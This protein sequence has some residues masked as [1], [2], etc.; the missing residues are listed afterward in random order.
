[1]NQP[2]YQQ[3]MQPQQQWGQPPMQQPMQPQQ[4]WGQ[5]PAQPMNPSQQPIAGA[6]ANNLFNQFLQQPVRQRADRAKPPDGT[7]VV[8]FTQGTK[9]DFSQKDGRPFL[10]LEY[11]VIEG[12]VP[13]V[14]GQTFGTPIFSANRMQL[15][16]L[17]NL[18]KMVFG[19]DLPQVAAQAQGDPSNMGRFIAQQLSR[20]YF[21]ALR[22]SR[23]PKQVAQK[24]YEE[25]FANHRW[26]GFSPQPINMAQVQAMSP[27]PQPQM[28]MPQPGMAPPPMLQPQGMPPQQQTF[29]QA[30]LPQ[31]APQQPVWQQPQQA[32]VQAQPQWQQPAPQQAPV[33]QFQQAFQLPQAPLPQGQLPQAQPP[34]SA[35]VMLPQA[36]AQ[37]LPQAP[38]MYIPGQR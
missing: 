31:A 3:P 32:P 36:G 17:A 30:P 4:Q 14:N 16:D 24:G 22:I 13:Q 9:V 5:P 28:Q 23:N 15:E 12:S 29:Q 33:Q 38:A 37:P 1:M 6:A 18:A 7:F 26:M 35:G 27:Q 11:Q 25:A 34:P 19:N 20:G 10:L 8:R 21:A 2:V